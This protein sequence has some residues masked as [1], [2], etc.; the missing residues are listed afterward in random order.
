V[1]VAV[2][3]PGGVALAISTATGPI[4]SSVCSGKVIGCVT[5]RGLVCNPSP[6]G[7]SPASEG[8]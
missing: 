2:L 8:I 3:T 4:E 1:I 5:T 7:F 6:A